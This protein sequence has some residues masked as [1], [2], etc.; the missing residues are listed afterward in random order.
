MLVE[1]G[2]SRHCFSLSF[3]FAKLAVVS[4]KEEYNAI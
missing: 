4:E 1:Y 3:G 2:G